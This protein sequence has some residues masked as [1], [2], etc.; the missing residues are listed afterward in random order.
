MWFHPFYVLLCIVSNEI[1]LSMSKGEHLWFFLELL[2]MILGAMDGGLW[3][4]KIS[5]Q[6][7]LLA[8][9][10]WS[11]NVEVS[12]YHCHHLMKATHHCT[13]FL[14]V[15]SQ[16]ICLTFV[17]HPSFILPCILYFI[18]LSHSKAQLVGWCDWVVFYSISKKHFST[19]CI[20]SHIS[21]EVV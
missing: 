4:K 11:S 16:Q 6:M 13:R 8:H 14:L 19:L 21:C 20:H 1:T 7:S 9:M 5:S 15:N 3:C 2:Y 17:V 18:N 12:C 10:I